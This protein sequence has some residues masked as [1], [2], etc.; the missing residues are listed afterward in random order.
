MYY[1]KILCLYNCWTNCISWYC[2][3]CFLLEFALYC[4]L[5]IGWFCVVICIHIV[6]IACITVFVL[7]LLGKGIPIQLSQESYAI[8]VPPAS[9]PD[10]DF[11]VHEYEQSGGLLSRSGAFG[12]D[13]LEN[14]GDLCAIRYERLTDAVGTFDNIF[15]NVVSGDG[16]LLELAI[17]TFFNTTRRLTQLL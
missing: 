17:I 13:P 2:E 5:G 4:R 7:K 9:L 15:S 12:V 3:V 6:L 10:T 8:P 11:A 1:N 14:R 16:H